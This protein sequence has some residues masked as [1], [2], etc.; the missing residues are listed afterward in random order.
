M[1]YVAEWMSDIVFC[2]FLSKFLKNVAY[3]T[4]KGRKDCYIII[5]QIA[6]KKSK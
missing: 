4:E 3:D 2:F 6:H 1:E 5:K